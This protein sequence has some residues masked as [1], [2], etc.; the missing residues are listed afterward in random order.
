M[1][2]FIKNFPETSGIYKIVSPTGRIYI[3]EAKN[4]KIRCSY[5]LNPNRIK[6]Q[7]AIYNSI[8]KYSPEAHSIEILEFCEIELLLE[9]ERYYQELY[10][11]VENG[12]NCF[13]TS[14]KNKK[15]VWSEETKRKISGN[16]KGEN[17]SF[18]GRKHSKESIDKISKRS[19]GENNP[20]YGGKLHSKEYIEKQVLSNSKKP[21]IIIDT[22]TNDY[23]KFINSKEA[24]NFFNCSP[25]TIREN[26]KNNWKLKKRY[27]IKDIT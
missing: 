23:F 12:L 5:Y 10:D 9:R 25:S 4:L 18:F 15:M 7:R 14:T 17:N 16:Q 27:I 2:D 1:I 26:K 3:G 22:L 20:N 24:A 13:F 6:G 11:S 8:V 19:S 21:L